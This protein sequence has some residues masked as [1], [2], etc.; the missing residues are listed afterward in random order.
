MAHS[1]F[2]PSQLH[3]IISCPSSVQLYHDLGVYNE[4]APSSLYAEEGTLLH[5]YMEK[6]LFTSDLSFIP[7][8]EHRTIV[9]AAAE[10]V[11]DFI[12][13][14]TQN[15][16]ILQE[17]RVEVPDVPQVYG[18]ADLILYIKDDEVPEACELHVFDYKFG[19]GVWVD[20]EDNPQFMSYLLG[21]VKA[22]NADT[23]GKIF[24]HVVQPR[25]DNFKWVDYSWNRLI[26]WR[27]EV[28][29]PTIAKAC[30]D[31]DYFGPSESA[32][33]W[34]AVKARCPACFQKAQEAASEIFK[35]HGLCKESASIS[36]EEVKAF[37]KNEAIIMSQI[38]AIKS[39]FMAELISGRKVPGYKLAY[40]RGTRKWKDED[41][42]IDYLSAQYD[43]DL[44]DIFETYLKSPAQAEK[45]LPRLKKDKQFID[46]I[47]TP[48]GAPKLVPVDSEEAN[49]FA[50]VTE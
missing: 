29:I 50:E 16:K 7:D 22:V 13:K 49:P 20:A 32:C 3:R 44:D 1:E 31:K 21:A 26:N 34:C 17:Q 19:A 41:K 45:L 14:Y 4:V 33:R 12:P 24:A 28:L 36:I 10:Y 48:Q 5:S 42:A 9:K 30:S 2:S 11:R 39:Y 8:A 35:L 15:V 37:F 6:A 38:K 43:I 40:S 25:L 18:T 46:L 23:R 27:N 47:Y